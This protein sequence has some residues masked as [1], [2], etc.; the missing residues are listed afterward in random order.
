MNK[1]YKV[2]ELGAM[3]KL[4]KRETEVVSALVYDATATGDVASFLGISIATLRVHLQSIFLKLG[5]NSKLELLKKV[6]FF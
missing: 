3:Y 5:I 1:K 6:M 4:T 2:K